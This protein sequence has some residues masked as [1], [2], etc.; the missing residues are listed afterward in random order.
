MCRFDGEV[1]RMFL[2]VFLRHA[3]GLDILQAY[4]E[5]INPKSGILQTSPS[6]ACDSSFRLRN[7]F[8]PGCHS[9]TFPKTDQIKLSDSHK[10]VQM[11]V[12]SSKLDST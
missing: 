1:F 8:I 10:N 11:L 3:T 6:I 7:V 5:V 4:A 9:L 12:D 2:V